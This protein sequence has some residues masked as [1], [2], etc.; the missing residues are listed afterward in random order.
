M[1]K[2]INV[3]E[4]INKIVANKQYKEIHGV[5]VDGFTAS[6][7]KAVYAA[8]SDQNQHKLNTVISKN[9]AGL[10]AVSEF[11]MKQKIHIL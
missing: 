8:L 9:A 4:D 10:I 5:L 6:A 3:I 2:K 1:T 11:A 7:I